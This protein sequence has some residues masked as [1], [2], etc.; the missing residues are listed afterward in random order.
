MTGPIAR[1]LIGDDHSLV[2]QA[3]QQLLQ[4]EF[5]VMGIAHDGRELVEKAERLRPDVVLADIG[6]PRLNGLDAG[7]RI[8]ESLPGTRVIYLT[9]S[10]DPVVEKEALARGGSAF[11]PKTI[12]R[13]QLCD[14][15]HKS[16]ETPE[17]SS[18]QTDV[19]AAKRHAHETT[20]DS[21]Q[22][23]NRQ[24]DVLQLLAE[25]L[26]MKQV[27][28]ELKLATR[29]VAF[30]KYRIM[31]TLGL[32]NDTELVQFAVRNHIVFLDEPRPAPDGTVPSENIAPRLP[33]RRAKAA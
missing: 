7:Q 19:V 28:G 10:S 8:L 24:R 11:L 20:V 25:G 22:L 9:M 32:T 6:M 31:E 33:L 17:Q 27:G 2:A 5:Q 13:R 14:A 23:T 29:T 18:L 16:L 12:G 1:V 26:S 4:P 21:L 30:H 3:I 15:I